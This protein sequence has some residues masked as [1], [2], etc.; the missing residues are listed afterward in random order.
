MSNFPSELRYT[1]E[2]AWIK[3]E[4]DEALLGITDYAQEQLGDILYVDLPDAESEITAGENFTEVESSKATSE[5]PS[6]LTGTVLEVNEELD[7]SPENINDDPY[8]A[9]IIRLKM[10]DA[11][12]L[13]GLLTAD[14]YEAGLEEEE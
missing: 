5:V 6:P 7:D 13:E 4:G 3:V 9:W 2:H 10:D 14:E 12:Q 8:E 11:S 1:R